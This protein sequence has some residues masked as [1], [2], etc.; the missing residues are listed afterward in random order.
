[1]AT[2]SSILGWR[3]LDRGAWWVHGVHVFTKSQTGLKQL[4]MHTC[5]D[6][7]EEMG[8]PANYHLGGDL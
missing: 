4:S 3:I 1:M 5:V 8:S 2:R 7:N 6:L